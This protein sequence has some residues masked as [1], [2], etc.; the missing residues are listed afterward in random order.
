MRHSIPIDVEDQIDKLI[1]S[2]AFATAEDVLR[3]AVAA[4]LRQEEDLAAIREGLADIEAG[5]VVTLD[6][7]DAEMRSKFIF[8]SDK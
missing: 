4:L 3:D 1:A 5:R 6:E 2:G 8:L 7:L